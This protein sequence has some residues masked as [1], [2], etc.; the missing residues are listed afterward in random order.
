M[1]MLVLVYMMV[2]RS[3]CCCRGN[4]PSDKVA[5]RWQQYTEAR[6][7]PRR[8]ID[9]KRFGRRSKWRRE[10][11]K[12]SH[13]LWSVGCSSTIAICGSTPTS[14]LSERHLTRFLCHGHRTWL[15][16]FIRGVG[17][18]WTVNRGWNTAWSEAWT[19][20]ELRTLAVL[21]FRPAHLVAKF[22]VVSLK[23]FMSVCAWVR[24]F[25]DTAEAIEVELTL[26]G[27]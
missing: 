20:T 13:L 7:Q 15:W 23:H 8:P 18:W 14:I 26:E 11:S 1:L 2:L 10:G 16:S 3:S 19:R 4:I 27:C 5:I 24:A 25:G 12:S 22:G 6:W 9:P 17:Q 21:L